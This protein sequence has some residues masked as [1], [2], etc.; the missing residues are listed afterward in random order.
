MNLLTIAFFFCLLFVTGICV[1]EE[2][3]L[4]RN[5]VIPHTEVELAIQNIVHELNETY[6]YPEKAKIASD[7]LLAKLRSGYFNQQY[8]FSRFN[9]EVTS[10]LFDS[11]RDSGF[12]LI[13][14]QPMTLSAIDEN[15]QESDS[16]PQDSITVEVLEN[17]IG[18]LKI[19]GDFYFPNENEILEEHLKVLSDVDALIIDLRSADKIAIN[20][21]QQLISYFVEPGLAIGNLRFNQ[22]IDTLKSFNTKGFDRFKQDFPLYII[23]SSFVA[24]SWEFFGHTLKHFDKAIIIGQETMGVGHIAKPI[25]VS[26][27]M[28][29]IMNHAVITHPVSNESWESYGVVPDYFF[30]GNSAFEKAVDLASSQVMNK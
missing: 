5:T 4:N 22:R 23:N 1:S 15:N 27:T 20:I 17:N 25:K 21:A 16:K 12:E 24:G 9:H 10:I 3:D 7:N 30:E 11:T 8:E 28:S 14:Q 29:I 18:Y 2:L 19:T 26:D 6:L 13:K